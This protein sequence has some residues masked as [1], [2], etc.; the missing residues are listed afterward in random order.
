M[1][2]KRI[3]PAIALEVVKPKVEQAPKRATK[4]LYSDEYKPIATADIVPLKQEKRLTR[5]LE[6][7]LTRFDEYGLPHIV[8]K[9][10][11]DSPTM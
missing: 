10:R 7:S 6:A 8:L 5:G 11:E 9:V 3:E 1:K 2:L 4:E